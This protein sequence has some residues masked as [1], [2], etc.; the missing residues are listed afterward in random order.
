LR[1]RYVMRVERV[2]M[3]A[4]QYG[5]DFEELTQGPYELALSSVVEGPA[6]WEAEQLARFLSEMPEGTADWELVVG[7]LNATLYCC[8]KPPQFVSEL[9]GFCDAVILLQRA[10]LDAW[11]EH[12]G[13]SVQWNILRRAGNWCE[14]Q[15]S[16]ERK[17]LRV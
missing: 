5:L 4:E 10:K 11:K 12:N 7:D 17:G 8:S 14:T 13:E 1:W 9:A 6:E 3:L 2:K 15:A 16:N